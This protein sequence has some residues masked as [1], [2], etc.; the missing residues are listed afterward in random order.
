M[1]W[2]ERAIF[3]MAMLGMAPAAITAEWESVT[4]NAVGD[5]FLID[6]SSIQR[7]ADTVFY[8]EYRE[9]PQPN[10]AFLEEPVDQPV[11]GVVL[12]WSANCTSKTQRLRQ[13]TAYDKAR[14]VIKRFSYGEN[15][16]LF[17]PKSG[18]SASTVLNNVCDR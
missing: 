3:C 4:Q 9:F 12:N 13:V 7:K 1:K 6:K 16:A 17:Q 11:Y 15:G 18:S 5:R 10:N 8:W 2:V 14:K